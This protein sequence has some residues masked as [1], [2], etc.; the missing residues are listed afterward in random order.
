M[1]MR[2]RG[3]EL[4]ARVIR[5]EATKT[6]KYAKFTIEPFERGFGTTVGNSLRRI[7]LSSLEGA[8]VTHARISGADHEFCSIDG[9]L[10]DVTD[11]VLNLKSIVVSIDGSGQKT[12]RLE[13]KGKGEIRAGDFQCE[14]GLTV[15]NP[16]Q[17]IA[18]LT[19]DRNFSIELT[20][21]VGR[22]YI[23]AAELITDETEL[24]IIALDALYSPVNRVRYRT[25]ETRVGQKTNYDRLILEIWTK[26]TVPP[27]D[28]M[29]EAAKILRK[30]LNPFVQYHE[31]GQ[32]QAS[33]D[34]GRPAQ[35]RMTI[36]PELARKLMMPIRD[37][38]LSVRASNCLDA[39]N[40]L[41]IGDLVR[42]DDA[43]LLQLRSFGKTSLDEVR[44]KLEP[45]GLTLGMHSLPEMSS[46]STTAEPM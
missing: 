37:L 25:E 32:D 19:A 5:D 38:D 33:A 36:D 18:T 17:H 23:P 15:Q 12:M 3:L 16:D 7:L 21:D 41:T 28:A 34:S 39:A 14:T 6:A 22:G 10:E 9:V 30:H 46:L 35:V 2:W 26:G 40:I 24:G 20:A 4:P 42:R 43:E 11:I 27:E 31:L 8:A 1:R 29:V 44:Q 45:L 13:R